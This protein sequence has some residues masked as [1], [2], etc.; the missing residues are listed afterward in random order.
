MIGSWI[1]PAT[2]ADGNPLRALLPNAATPEARAEDRLRRITPR[3]ATREWL[4]CD[5]LGAM[6][7]NHQPMGQT[8]PTNAPQMGK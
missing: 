2:G 6:V 8:R 5:A 3:T 4:N 1:S 7:S